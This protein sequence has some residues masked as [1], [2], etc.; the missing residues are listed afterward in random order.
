MLEYIEVLGLP[1]SIAMF[2][3]VIFFIMQL[4]GEALTLK[5]KV[6]PEFMHLKNYFAR[7]KKEQET[8]AEMTRTI[9][10]MNEFLNEVKHRYSDDNIA[11]RD[12]WMR[13]V[14][15][16]GLDN[17]EHIENINKK[18]DKLEEYTISLIIDNKRNTIIDFASRVANSNSYFTREQFNRVFKIYHEYENIIEEQGLTNGEVDVAYRII[19]EAYMD[20]MRNDTFIEDL[21]GYC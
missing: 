11:L 14:E 4:I 8:I 10:G 20:C 16:R 9:K 12:E 2:L 18:L 21:R 13:V 3:V 1:A 7:R 17:E 15:K 6:V 5:G 19:E